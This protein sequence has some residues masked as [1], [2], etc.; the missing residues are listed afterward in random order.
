[1][2]LR[3]PASI[4]AQEADEPCT[5]IVLKAK[6]NHTYELLFN[7]ILLFL[8][9]LFLLLLLFVFLF[10]LVIAVVQNH[11]SATTTAAAIVYWSSR[12]SIN[13]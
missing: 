7:V 3:S 13:S 4:A 6:E 10:L 5:L 9:F 8:F 1:M 11:A 12:Q 2:R